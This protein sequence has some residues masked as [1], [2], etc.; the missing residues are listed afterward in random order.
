MALDLAAINN[1]NMP[2]YC[3]TVLKQVL[4]HPELKSSAMKPHG[5]ST[6]EIKTL[7]VLPDNIKN[8]KCPLF[9]CYKTVPGEQLRGCIGTFSHETLHPLLINFALKSAFHD[10]RFLPIKLCE[11]D[12]LQCTVSLLHNFNALPRGD[13]FSWTFNKHGV[14]I[15]FAMNQQQY[16]AT[17]LPSVP[18][19]VGTTHKEVI[20]SLIRKAGYKGP[21]DQRLLDKCLVTTYESS[22]FSNTFKDIEL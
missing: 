6:E 18:P 12:Q 1:V 5:L 17:Y 22:D 4:C 7:P 2:K 9:V 16:S 3:F 15:Q 13:C 14:E 21:I 19:M 11:L 20:S 8:I 10:S